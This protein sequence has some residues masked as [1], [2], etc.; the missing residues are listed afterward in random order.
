MSIKTLL[1]KIEEAAT[2]LVKDIKIVDG[3]KEVV[4]SREYVEPCKEGYKRDPETGA[5]VR[6]SLKERRDASISA[7]KAA[8][9]NSTKRNKAISMKRRSALIKD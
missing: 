8:N 6:M 7:T 4:V 9:K 2:K 5:C 1:N 3:K